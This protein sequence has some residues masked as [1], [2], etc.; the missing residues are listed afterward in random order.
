[1]SKHTVA[2]LFAGVAVLTS[3][4]AVGQ[5]TATE[6]I[7]GR[8]RAALT[9]P[10]PLIDQGSEVA[11]RAC[12]DCHGMD[13]ISDTPGEPHL[14]GQRTVYLNRVLQAYQ[15]GARDGGAMHAAIGMLNSEALIAVSAYYASLAPPVHSAEAEQAAPE[16]EAGDPFSGIRD[17]MKRCV[18]CHGED[19]NSSASGMPNLTAQ[20][21]VYFVVS[22]QA[23]V[24]GK[25]DHKL[26]KRLAADLDE[27]TLQEM[28]LY[29]AVQTP[30]AT[31]TTGDGD[32]SAGQAL[33]GERCANCH[34][35]DGNASGAEM[36]SLAGQDARYFIKAMEAYQDGSRAH[37]Q[38]IDAVEGLDESDLQ[39]LATFYATQAPLRRDVR[40]PLTTEEW[41]SRCERCH[42]IDGNSTDPRF[43]M[44]AGQDRQYLEATL[45]AYADQ[46]RGN[47]IM[48][49]MSEPL[50]EADVTRIAKHYSTRIPKAV[51]YMQLPCE[52][53]E[54]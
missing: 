38:M 28:G 34:G 25:R 10:R 37:Q 35:E 53:S 47:S 9:D 8:E 33:A 19:G 11:A 18:R 21:P 2:L 54:N 4:I 5:P 31:K 7:T 30:A 13:G 3:G 15:A 41:I 43:P 6:P 24:D 12:A 48:H 32:A 50:S 36:P 42:G 52:D 27:R 26:M 44:L 17:S 22:M 20:S 14:A 45:R 51:V 46:G 49:A 39:N 1:M 23:Y 29:Y 40:M 16:P